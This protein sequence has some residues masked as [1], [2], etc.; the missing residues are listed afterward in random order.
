MFLRENK[1]GP[2]GGSVPAAPK[3]PV[4][5]VAFAFHPVPEPLGSTRVRRKSHCKNEPVLRESAAGEACLQAVRPSDSQFRPSSASVLFE[6]R[7]SL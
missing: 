5:E 7:Q 6:A 3:Y 4:I 1:K 2:T